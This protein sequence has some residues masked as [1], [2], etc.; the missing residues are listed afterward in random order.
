[1]SEQASQTSI[2]NWAL[3]K[4]GADR[5]TNPDDPTER[6]Q[7]AAEIY[8]RVLQSEL[9]KNVWKFATQTQEVGAE[10]PAPPAPWTYRYPMPGNALRM[11]Q[12]GPDPMS[13]ERWAI[14]GRHIYSLRE[15][16]LVVRFIASDIAEALFDAA[17]VEA[18]ATKLALEL[19]PRIRNENS[20]IAALSKEYT[21][22]VREARRIGA[23]ETP[24]IPRSDSDPWVESR[25]AGPWI[26]TGGGQT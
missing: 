2:T 10:Q 7:A 8:H 3:T 17:F 6:A 11:L 16:P 26:A 23:I 5:I 15:S 25:V 9:R 1:M 19:A 21:M 24:P 13:S 18:F 12:V 14:E 4:L 22:A 20:L